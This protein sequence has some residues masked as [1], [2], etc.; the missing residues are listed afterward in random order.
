MTRPAPD[1]ID[2][3][4]LPRGVSHRLP[5]ALLGGLVLLGAPIYGTVLYDELMRSEQ[6]LIEN[7]TV[8]LALIASAV[9]VYAWHLTAVMR[10]Q[11]LMKTWLAFFIV[12]GVFLAGEEISWG[13]H[14]FGWESPAWFAQQNIQ[15]ETNLHNLFHAGEQIPKLL[16]HLAAIFGGILWPLLVARGVIGA[17]RVGSSLYWLLPT[18]AVMPT[19]VIAIAIRVLERIL[20][21]SGLK[22][23]GVSI[24]EFKELNELF[25]ILFAVL[26]LA[27]LVVR[28][29]AYAGASPERNG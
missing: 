24:K 16:L 25:L 21:N 23:S 7:A 19:A 28:A 1:S 13:Q 3:P 8:V 17:P 26:Y 9:A 4:D 12:G 27:S 6:G 11:W 29:R 20:A 18:G 14:M 22:Q 2:P 10:P 15:R 5:V